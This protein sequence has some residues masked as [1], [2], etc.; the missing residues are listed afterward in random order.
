MPFEVRSLRAFALLKSW[1]HAYPPLLFS[2]FDG[3]T[4]AGKYNYTNIIARLKD[5]KSRIDRETEEWKEKGK[6]TKKLR[7]CPLH[8]PL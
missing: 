8:F 5:L 1:A 7:M 2:Q 6:G 3:N 4:A